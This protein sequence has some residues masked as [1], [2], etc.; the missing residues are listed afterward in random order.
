MFTPLT[1]DSKEIDIKSVV[2]VCSINDTKYIDFRMAQMQ[3]A[4]TYDELV[5]A[6]SACGECEGC[7]THIPWISQIVCRCTNV[8]INDILEAHDFERVP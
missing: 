2:D 4:R 5:K 3:G 6:T 1:E 7:K 8:T